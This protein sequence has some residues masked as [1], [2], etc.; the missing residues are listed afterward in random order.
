[1]TEALA[2]M[3]F[4]SHV[5][6]KAH[7]LLTLYRIARYTRN[8]RE[9]WN[10]HRSGLPIPPLQFRAGFTAYHGPT[11]TPIG[12][13]HEVFGSNF[14]D[15]AL[16]RAGGVMLDLGANI[17]YVSL[18]TLQRAPNVEIYAY[19]PNPSAAAMLRRNLQENGFSAHVF[20]EA[21]GGCESTIELKTVSPS[22]MSTAY[23]LHESQPAVAHVQAPM[24]S[25]RQVLAR[26]A[27]PNIWLMK[28]DIEGGEADALESVTPAELRRI[29][30][31]FCEYHD[32][33]VPNARR[34]CEQALRSAGFHLQLREIVPGLGIIRAARSPANGH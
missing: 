3:T 11:D 31:I 14:Y 12:L 21:V 4:K 15:C 9:V 20:Q 1:V 30:N 27:A 17:G 26:V 6:G 2:E 18:R 8:W 13:L 28:M 32:S 24:V 19:E 33:L 5:H 10:C 22:T 29:E 16:P 25:L 34:R 7:A 23:S